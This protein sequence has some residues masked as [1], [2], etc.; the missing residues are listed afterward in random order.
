MAPQLFRFA[1]TVNSSYKIKLASD[2]I[3]EAVVALSYVV[4]VLMCRSHASSVP[5]SSFKYR[6]FE[7]RY[8]LQLNEAL[9]RISHWSPYTFEAL[10]V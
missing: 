3:S 2:Y 9:A 5:I 6:I 10:V 4:I 7:A 1:I 8:S